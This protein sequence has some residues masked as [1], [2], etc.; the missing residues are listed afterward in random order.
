MKR[1]SQ[2]HFTFEDHQH[3]CD[4]DG[5]PLTP[6]AEPRSQN[7]SLASDSPFR[8]LVR[9]RVTLSLLLLAGVVSS[10]L[11][12]GYYEAASQANDDVT[13]NAERPD[14]LVRL[15]PSAEA[16]VQPPV[17]IRSPNPLT[18]DRRIT[19]A[20]DCSRMVRRS[21]TTYRSHARVRSSTP[22][23]KHSRAFE[24]AHL[25]KESKVNA[26]LKRTGSILKKT[27]SILKRPF[28]L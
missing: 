21:A 12:V 3:F 7:V 13:A 19:T 24:N 27:V 6:Y 11:L 4:F 14:D 16:P 23:R 1:C 18:A 2:C 15:V 28:E 9:S 20:K 26:I 17:D 5:T 25:Q 10:A 8:R 22:F